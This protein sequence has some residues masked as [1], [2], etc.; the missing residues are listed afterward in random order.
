[1]NFQLGSK[2]LI[3]SEVREGELR[4]LFPG[5]TKIE[6]VTCRGAIRSVDKYELY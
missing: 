4:R 6:F 2:V 1:M 5:G 3:K